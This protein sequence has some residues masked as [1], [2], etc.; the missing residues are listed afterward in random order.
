MAE[1][2]SLSI[3]STGGEG[4]FIDVVELEELEIDFWAAWK[5]EDALAGPGLGSIPSA[6]KSLIQEEAGGK[7]G[8]RQSV[9]GGRHPFSVSPG[10][11]PELGSG[12][13]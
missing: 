7:V 13:G 2:P 1:S 8:T 10:S 3:R 12:R 6:V 5:K 9:G 4:E 11:A